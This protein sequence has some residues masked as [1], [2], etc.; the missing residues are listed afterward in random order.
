MVLTNGLHYWYLISKNRLQWPLILYFMQNIPKKCSQSSRT[1][2]LRKRSFGRPK[3]QVSPKPEFN[4]TSITMQSNLNYDVISAVPIKFRFSA[5]ILRTWMIANTFGGYIP[6]NI[7]NLMST[8]R[9]SNFTINTKTNFNNMVNININM[10][11]MVM[12]STVGT[13]N[14]ITD[15]VTSPVILTKKKFVIFTKFKFTNSF[16]YN[17]NFTGTDKI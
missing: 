3:L 4:S 2:N 8:I 9:V 7:K 17:T 1:A 12:H 16:R 11:N 10:V 15:R 14:R 6:I 5:R 13:T